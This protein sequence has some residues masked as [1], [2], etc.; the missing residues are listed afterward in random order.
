MVK[1]HHLWIQMVMDYG[2]VLMGN[3]KN[4]TAQ[5]RTEL[6]NKSFYTNL[7]AKFLS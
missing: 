7:E 2:R 6:K 3:E 1:L 4:T 5:Q